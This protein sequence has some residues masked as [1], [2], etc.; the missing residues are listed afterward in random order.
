MSARLCRGRASVKN[1]L[2]ENCI[3]SVLIVD[4]QAE[5]R[6]RFGSGDVGG[7]LPDRQASPRELRNRVEGMAR[8]ARRQRQLHERMQLTYQAERTAYLSGTPAMEVYKSETREILKR[9]LSNR[10][11]FP[12]CI[13]ALDAALAG[14][15][16][17][18]SSDQIEPLRAILLDNNATVMKEME[19][20]GPPSGLPLN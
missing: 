15:I 2:R 19:R 1:T 4:I 3:V 10:L 9:F 16:P 14:L 8:E 20:R 5:G 7:E 6:A 11:S 12:H 17:N 18:L 13:A